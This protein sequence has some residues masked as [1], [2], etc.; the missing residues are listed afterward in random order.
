ML[1]SVHGSSQM[2]KLLKT[3]KISQ[4]Q[5]SIGDRVLNANG[6]FPTHQIVEAPASSFS[7]RD[8]GL[9][10]RIPKKIKTRR[11]IVNDLDNRHG[12][13]NFET[14]NGDYFKKIRFQELGIPV[15]ANYGNISKAAKERLEND[16]TLELTTNPLFKSSK[17]FSTPSTIAGLLQVKNQP[18]NSNEFLEKVKPELKSLRKPFLEWIAKSRPQHLNEKNKDLFKAF[19]EETRPE[20]FKQVTESKDSIPSS[21]YEKLSGTAGLSY[22]LKGRIIQTPNGPQLS[23]LVPGRVVSNTN[24]SVIG[25]VG[26]FVTDIRNTETK[27]T[28]VEKLISQNKTNDTTGEFARQVL[29]PT[30]VK[31]AKLSLDNRRLTVHASP[32]IKKKSFRR[33]AGHRN[34]TSLP[35]RDMAF[36]SMLDLLKTINIKSDSLNNKNGSSDV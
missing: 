24:D 23:R 1:K 22:N 28:Y 8:F 6:A 4:L 36:D 18:L 14:L 10:M 26:G 30:H 12:L 27:N 11:I 5:N 7:R 17:A 9:K 29:V 25:T 31:G 34:T 15:E 13:P 3:T 2:G 16:A 35:A 21:H 19:I 33:E 32:V 20:L